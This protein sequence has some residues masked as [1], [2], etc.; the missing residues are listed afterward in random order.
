MAKQDTVA[1]RRQI[2]AVVQDKDL[3]RK[4]VTEIAIRYQ[5]RPGGYTRRLKL[6]PRQGD[7]SPLSLLSLIP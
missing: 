7:G 3:T 6:P 4:L 5:D 1:S 2:M